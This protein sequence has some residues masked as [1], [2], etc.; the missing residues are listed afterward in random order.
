MLCHCMHYYALYFV[1]C[2][3]K[4][5]VESEFYLVAFFALCVQI[6]WPGKVMFRVMET[7]VLYTHSPKASC[8]LQ[9][10]KKKYLQIMV[11]KTMH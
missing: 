2:V 5:T 8:H 4:S 6:L 7:F 11:W 3:L 9:K 1:L 10:K